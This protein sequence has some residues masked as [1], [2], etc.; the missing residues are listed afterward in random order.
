METLKKLRRLAKPNNCCF[1]FDLQDGCRHMGIN[2]AY[3]ECNACTSACGGRYFS[4]ALSHLGGWKDYHRIFVKVMKGL[5]DTRSAYIGQARSAADW[6]EAKRF[7]VTPARLQQIHQKATALLGQASLPVYIVYNGTGLLDG[8][9]MYCG[10]QAV[11]TML[12]HFTSRNPELMRHLRHL[13]IFLDL[14][15]IELQAGYIQKGRGSKVRVYWPRIDDGWYNEWDGGRRANSNGVTHIVY[16]DSDEEHLNMDTEEYEAVGPEALQEVRSWSGV[17]GERWIGELDDSYRAVGIYP[18][19][20][21]RNGRRYGDGTT[22]NRNTPVQVG[23]GTTDD[24]S[25]PVRVMSA[26]TVTSVAAAR[27]QSVFITSSG[28]TYTVGLNGNGELGDGTKTTRTTPVQVMSAH[29]VSGAAAGSFHTVFITSSGATYATGKN[30][31]G[32]LGDGT[33]TTRTTPV[34]VMSAHSVSSAAAGYIHTVFVTSS[35]QAHATGRNSNGQLGDGTATDRSTPV[36]VMSA[37]TVASVAAGWYH[38][39]FI[40]SSGATY[41]T[42]LNDYGQ[43]GDGTTTDRSTPVQVMSTHTVSSAAAADICADLSNIVTNYT[44]HSVPNHTPDSITNGFPNS[45]P[46]GFPD[47]ITDSITNGFPNAHSH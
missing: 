32:Q 18:Y 19:A 40:T 29:T 13:W 6:R 30:S 41:T 33:T 28:A 27:H 26:H 8:V 17:L 10:N 36:H 37:H 44:S 42:G 16:E 45:V 11:M 1:S 3:Q 2:P 35:G 21:G 5:A 43:L 46:N 25:T 15:A 9:R 34:Q 4:A 31:N 23:D 38:T 12:S 22:T 7:R 47:S 20:T 24:R 39:V 14:N